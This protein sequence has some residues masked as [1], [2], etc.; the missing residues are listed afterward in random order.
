MNVRTSI[1]IV[2]YN[3]LLLTQALLDSL[4]RHAPGHEVVVVDNGS[5]DGSADTLQES[6]FDV[7]LVRLERNLGFGLANNR[8]ADH[9]TEEFLFFLNNDSIV[10][11]DVPAALA[12]FM[13]D[14]PD[15]GLCGPKL[16]NAD[17]SYQVSHGFDPSLWNEWRTRRLQKRGG[18]RDQAAEVPPHPDWLSG[19]ALMTRKTLFRTVGGFDPSYFMYF[20]DADLCCR[21][22]E[23]GFRIAYLPEISLVHLRRRTVDRESSRINVEY[24]RSQIRYYQFHRGGLSI[25]LLRAYLFAKFGLIWIVSRSNT[26]RQRTAAAIVRLAIGRSSEDPG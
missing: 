2:N 15:I 25:V 10:R 18:R 21:I 9:A 20:E 8:G 7:K 5:T 23:A 11:S 13:I 3:G 12:A 17:G 22:R 24:R 19:A 1:I 16:L 14:H 26:T 4:R 6:L